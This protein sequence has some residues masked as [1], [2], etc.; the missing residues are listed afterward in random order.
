[1]KEMIKALNIEAGKDTP[2]V[3]F[4]GEARILEISG[5][6]YPENAAAFY[7]PIF[8]WLDNYLEL[9][10]AEARENPG[11]EQAVTKLRVQA[12]YLNSS[13]SKVL[14]NLFDR[15][16]LAVENGLSVEVQWLYHVENETLYECGKEFQEDLEVLPFDLVA[17]DSED[18]S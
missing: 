17:L 18:D 14:L 11:L 4:D 7:D 5:D 15:L 10:H 1:M 9:L 13:S 12:N 8:A 2:Y 6:S 3:F 16:E